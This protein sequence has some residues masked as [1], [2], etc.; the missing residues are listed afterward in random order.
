MDYDTKALQQKVDAALYTLQAKF[1]FWGPCVY[2]TN[3]TVL[4]LQGNRAATDGRNIYFDYKFIEDATQANINGVAVHEM[5]HILRMH[6]IRMGDREPEVW[7]V[8]CDTIINADLE[9][10]FAHYPDQFYIED[11]YNQKSFERDAEYT[12]KDLNKYTEEELY[13]IMLAKLDQ[14]AQA[15]GYESYSD[16]KEKTQQT[17][18]Q[19]IK[20]ALDRIDKPACADEGEGALSQEERHI[21][22]LINECVESEKREAG[23]VPGHYQD[24]IDHRKEPKVHWQDKLRQFLVQSFQKEYSWKEFEKRTLYRDLY[25]PKSN[26]K[27][28]IGSLGIALDSSGSMY[29]QFQ[30]CID[31]ISGLVQE[32]NPDVIHSMQFDSGVHHYEKLEAVEDFPIVEG[33]SWGGTAFDPIFEFVKEEEFNHEIV[34]LLIFTDGYASFSADDPGYPVMAIIT[35]DGTDSYFPDWVEIVRIPAKKEH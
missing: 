11:Y 15:Q 21:E 4:D 17:I 35:E 28:S 23:S 32:V 8:A 19:M 25:L 29:G 10:Y 6:H 16:K 14:Q 2:W 3:A 24:Y 33:A 26:P 31:E 34:A 12:I 18:E 1:P 22:S 5:E 9:E 27:E 13:D 7:N 30:N 20:E